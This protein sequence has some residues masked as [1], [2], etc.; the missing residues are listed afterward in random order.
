MG[1][2]MWRLTIRGLAAHRVRLMLSAVAVVLGVAFVAGSLVL[3][4]TLDD[5]YSGVFRSAR[6]G[7]D[8]VVRLA[9]PAGPEGSG[10]RFPDSV[11]DRV[12]D[13]PGVARADGV[14]QGRVRILDR[15]GEPVTTGVAPNLGVSW[16]QPDR[17][18]PL[19]VVGRGRPPRSAGEVAID[20]STAQRIGARV[21]DRVRLVGADA[22]RSYRLSARISLDG[23]EDLGGVTVAAFTL[24]EAQRVVGAPGE[25]DEVAVRV[26]P[27][28][29]P[30]RVRRR[31]ARALGDRFDVWTAERAARSSGTRLRDLLALL[32]GTL[33]GFAVV[34]MAVAGLLIG[35]TFAVVGAR[36]RRETALLRIAGATGRQVVATSLAEAVLLGLVAGVVG[37]V[38]GTV[39]AAAAL[40]VLRA[41]GSPT[42]TGGIHVQVASTVIPLVVGVVATVVA[43][44]PATVRAARVPVLVA[45]T[46]D[47]PVVGRRRSV[48]VPVALGVGSLLLVGIGV[49]RAGPGP[50]IDG[51]LIWVVVG[52][53]G[54]VAAGVLALEPLV[55]RLARRRPRS[56]G[57]FARGLARAELARDPRRAVAAAG[58]LV[59]VTAMVVGLLTFAASARAS[60]AATI[61]AGL[62]A[63]I[64]LR[65][66]QFTGFSSGAADAV[67]GTR[68][69]SA[70]NPVQFRRVRVEG[71]V[72]T[73]ASVR[74]SDLAATVDL[75]MVS[76]R[77][78]DLGPG[79]VLLSASAADELGV[80]V[81]DRV[82]VQMS[83]LTRDL[84]VVGTFSRTDF[85]GAYVTPAVVD[86]ADYADGFGP[87]EPDTLVLVRTTGDPD[88]VVRRIRHRLAGPFPDVE[89]LDRAA[90]RAGQMASADRVLAAALALVVLAMALAVL[91]VANALVLAVL[92]RTR[93]IGLLRAVGMT[94]GQVRTMVRAEALAVTVVGSLVGTVVGVVWGLAFATVLSGWGIGVLAVPVVRIGTFVVLVALAGLAAAVVPAR[95][96]VRI[97]VLRAVAGN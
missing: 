56:V 25:L 37:V 76:G 41:V 58:S 30:E 27:G 47:R 14:V 61:D 8:L 6:A 87:D 94:A 45:L 26:D 53:V 29:D 73:V 83:R 48:A 5:T 19:R 77:A 96:A 17:N 79:R 32:R 88:A 92:E 49:G 50:R 91:G 34:G 23:V 62:R 71:A 52:A 55:A 95:R 78:Q 97:D 70:V 15:S 59:V 38:V 18:G 31:V 90:Y 20:A 57:P 40:A 74:G 85:S 66:R 3:T 13:I 4:D 12:A 63:G 60:V 2:A 43:A 64:V 51:A 72:E 80:A 75:G 42:P 93:Q 33:L 16:S 68:G 21:G 1:A 35:Q 46:D 89:V 9:G 7:T 11:R 84:E 36:R 67:A 82:A 54:L 28:A 65:D 24:G 39:G 81:G 69:V 44:L 86:R 10:E 22:A